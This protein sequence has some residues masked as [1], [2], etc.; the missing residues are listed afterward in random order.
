MV[1][2]TGEGAQTARREARQMR[3]HLETIGKLSDEQLQSELGSFKQACLIWSTLQPC[4]CEQ[5]GALLSALQATHCAQALHRW[6]CRILVL[7]SAC[8]HMCCCG[9]VRLTGRA[10]GRRCCQRQ[11][12]LP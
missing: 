8:I 12:S 5:P 7:A 6:L 1:A 11:A 10:Y 4:E 3:Q 2:F 9:A